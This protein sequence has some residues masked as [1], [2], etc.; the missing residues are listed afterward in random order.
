MKLT[1]LDHKIQDY[2]DK[3]L[4]FGCI[5]RVPFYP[6]YHYI[7]ELFTCAGN[8]DKP[9]EWKE[10]RGED[11]Y[12]RIQLYS[13]NFGANQISKIIGKPMDWWKLN[14]FERDTSNA[15]TFIAFADME[16]VFYE[17]KLF[18]KN[19]L[20]RPTVAKKRVFKFLKLV[21]KKH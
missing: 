9:V 21:H 11:V 4:C 2:A 5:I 20:E 7:T 18:D 12:V 6:N 3:R 14:A 1:K 10:R 15:E 8:I 19:I 17:R 16:Q 13:G